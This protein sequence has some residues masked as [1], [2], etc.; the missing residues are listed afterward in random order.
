MQQLKQKKSSDVVRQCS[1]AYLILILSLSF[2]S[3]TSIKTLIQKQHFHKGIS[4]H[5]IIDTWFFDKIIRNVEFYHM[6][7]EC[8][9]KKTVLL[10]LHNKNNYKVKISWK[11]N[12]DTQFEKHTKGY[13][14]Q[15]QFVLLKGELVQGGC[16][17]K[18][19]NEGFISPEEINPAFIADLRGF[20]YVD[21]KVVRIQ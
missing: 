19:F 13:R 3:F 8:N 16:G 20:E 18:N 10:K 7:G 4:Q 5:K 11:E 12:F 14:G 9:G 15:K 17:S 6:I 1:F 2:Y 21:I